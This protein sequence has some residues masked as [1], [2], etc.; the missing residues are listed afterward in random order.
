MAKPQMPNFFVFAHRKTKLETM[1][2]HFPYAIFHFTKKTI[3][4]NFYFTPF[5]FNFFCG[6]LATTMTKSL[7]YLVIEMHQ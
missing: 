3:L 4:C 7:L 5:N 2:T 6:S 1:Y